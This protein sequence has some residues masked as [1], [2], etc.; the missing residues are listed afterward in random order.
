MV[1]SLNMPRGWH[2]FIS[3]ADDRPDKVPLRRS[4]TLSI[5]YSYLWGGRDVWCVVVSRG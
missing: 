1:L 5:M 3:S 4:I 2:C